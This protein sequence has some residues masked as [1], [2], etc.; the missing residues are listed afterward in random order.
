MKKKKFV[1]TLYLNGSRY[2]IFMTQPSQIPDLLK[3]FHQQKELVIIE[4]NGKIYNKLRI[5]PQYIKEGD[6]MEIITIVGGG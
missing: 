6:K 4:Y 1:L 2:K 3:F 5:K